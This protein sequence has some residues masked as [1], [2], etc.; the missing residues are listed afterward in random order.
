MKTRL[1]HSMLLLPHLF[2]SISSLIQ[3]VKY[4][5]SFRK[6]REPWDLSLHFRAKIT[7]QDFLSTN[8]KMKGTVNSSCAAQL[9]KKMEGSL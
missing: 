7:S 9:D 4:F 8:R 1:E 3:Q 6:S 2:L 5:P